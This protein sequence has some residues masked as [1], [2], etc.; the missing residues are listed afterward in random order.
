MG[1]LATI[2]RWQRVDRM[3]GI[4]QTP[5]PWRNCDAPRPQVKSSPTHG[6]KVR[7][8]GG[9]RTIR[10]RRSLD[11]LGRHPGSLNGRYIVS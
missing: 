6:H 1:E 5:T 7:I 11:H 3:A 9:T 8:G 10:T 4:T 2:C